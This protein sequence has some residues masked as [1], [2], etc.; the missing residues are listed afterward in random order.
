MFSIVFYEFN[1]DGNVRVPP[2]CRHFPPL[3]VIAV[4]A[5]AVEHAVAGVE[6]VRLAAERVA[7]RG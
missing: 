4:L 6:Q 1:R 5:D 3:V 2:G 7:L